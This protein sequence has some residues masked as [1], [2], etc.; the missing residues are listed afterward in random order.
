M[1]STQ[2]D[3]HFPFEEEPEEHRVRNQPDALRETI[4][5]LGYAQNNQVR[6]YGEVFDL[7]SDPVSVGERLVFVDALERNS[8]QVR[9]VRIP[10]A[11]VRMARTKRRGG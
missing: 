2:F 5:R 7:L 3:E 8:G 6:L 4:K 10:P 11:I 9:R 1:R